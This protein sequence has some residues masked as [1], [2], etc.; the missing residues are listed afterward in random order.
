VKVSTFKRCRC[1]G[2]DGRELG[3]RCPQLRRAD[4]SLNPRHGSWSWRTELPAE[5]KT[6]RRV[7]K[8]GAHPTQGDAEREGKRVVEL[9][10]IPAAGET[11]ARERVEIL[12]LVDEALKRGDPLPD[13]DDIRRRVKTG[14]SILARVTVGEFLT[15]W[16]E[17]KRDIRST[18]RNNY[19]SNI[20]LYLVPHLG[21]L[22]LD[23]LRTAH[24]SAMFDAIDEANERIRA[25][26]LSGTRQRG[27]LRYRKEVGPATKQRIRATLRSALSDAIAEGLV[28]VNVAKLVKLESGKRPKGLVWTKERVARWREVREQIA[29][30]EAER[31]EA[32]ERRDREAVERLSGEIETLWERERPSPV[33]VWT[34][35][36]LGT[37]LDFI[38]EHRLYAMFHLIAFRGLRRGEAC[39]LRWVDLDLDEGVAT[40]AEQLIAVGSDIEAG[41][42]KSDAGNRDVALDKGTVGVLRAHRVR[43]LEDR[44]RW[45][46]AW[47]DS[48]RMFVREDGSELHPPSVTDLFGDLIEAC[49]L[50]PIRLHDLRH[51]AASIAKAAGIDTKVISE[52]LGHSSRKIT[53]DTYTSIFVEVAREAAEASAAIVPRAVVGDDQH[54]PHGLRLVSEERSAGT[55]KKRS[56]KKPQV[57][58]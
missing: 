48:G 30:K 38:A 50:P 33:M 25:L 21:H 26:R 49:G 32:V 39:G 7:V 13:A 51:T 36:Q 6:A 52:M 45:S 11:G 1:C 55:V 34:P 53:D 16:L 10:S 40:V 22:P 41:E 5:S 27:D 4:G 3:Q 57:R 20:R 29:A 42:P 12:A 9:L 14:Q 46:T 31:S 37:F 54:G 43:Q 18:T 24:A 44:L 56:G 58:G 19:A 28:T 2:E 47:V 17:G 35:V 15:A 8:R 23:K